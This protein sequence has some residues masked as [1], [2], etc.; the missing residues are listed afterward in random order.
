ML[1]LCLS[2]EG[3]AFKAVYSKLNNVDAVKGIPNE[4]LTCM[5]HFNVHCCS[6]SI[7]QSHMCIYF[8]L[9]Y[10]IQFVPVLDNSR[11]S[12]RLCPKSPLL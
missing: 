5:N 8:E 7:P 11:H 4:T 3:G 1:T 10:S 9:H 12:I 2:H 6:H